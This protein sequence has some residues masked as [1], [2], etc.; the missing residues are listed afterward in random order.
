MCDTSRTCA[1]CRTRLLLFYTKGTI[2]TER[3]HGGT[4]FVLLYL[5]RTILPDHVHDVS[6]LS[7]TGY[8]TTRTGTRCRTSLFLL[9]TLGTML[10]ERVY[11]VVPV[12]SSFIHEI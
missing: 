10:T 1:R 7:F 5:Q 6:P 2:I 3:L 12:S 8:D 11:G 4:G 9:Y